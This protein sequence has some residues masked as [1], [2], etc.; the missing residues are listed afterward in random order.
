MD[1]KWTNWVMN[2]SQKNDKKKTLLTPKDVA[3][4]L[5]VSPVTV[6]VWAQ[7]NKLPFITTPGGHRRFKQ[8]DVDK[9]AQQHGAR[10][11]SAYSILIVDDDEQHAE[12]LSE[13]FRYMPLDT[14]T[15]IAHDGFE[16]GQLI[17]QINPDCVLLD[18]MMPGIDGFSVCQR[19]K[20]DPVTSNIRVI[21]MTG[22]T[23]L[24]N[25]QRIMQAGAEQCLK[26]P[27]SRQSINELFE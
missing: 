27:I 26:K 15:Y 11:S 24:E 22:Y 21:A 12:L 14:S 16:A 8:N 7:E 18:L 3:N 2:V 1:L 13:Y 19:I 20:G 25:V 5:G 9:F 6:R 17:N 10:K 23:D 4:Q